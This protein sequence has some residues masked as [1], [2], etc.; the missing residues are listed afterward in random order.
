MHKVVDPDGRVTFL[1]EMCDTYGML[2]LMM[3]CLRSAS[4]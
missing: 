3:Q 4:T 2:T 1:T